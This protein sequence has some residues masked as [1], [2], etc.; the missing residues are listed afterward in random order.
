M[1]CA[2]IITVAALWTLPTI[3]FGSDPG[4]EAAVKRLSFDGVTTIFTLTR[5]RIRSD[6]KLVARWTFRNETGRETTFRF[7][8]P[9]VDAFLYRDGK[10]LKLSARRQTIRCLSVR[11]NRERPTR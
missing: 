5:T 8:E 3:A 1:K 10:R 6:Q 2:L 11:S 4:L 9:S 7:Y